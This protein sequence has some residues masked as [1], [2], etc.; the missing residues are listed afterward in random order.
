MK[1]VG[2][3]SRVAGIALVAGAVFFGGPGRAYASTGN[4]RA[5]AK[6]IERLS[7]LLKEKQSSWAYRR[8]GSIAERKS[9]GVLGKR[10]A[11]ALGYFDYQRGYFEQAAKWLDLA[12]GD[13]LLGDYDAYW[14]AQTNL[15]L[16]DNKDALAELQELRKD[17]PD[18]V[19]TEQ[20]LQSLGVAAMAANQPADGVTA[21][22]AYPQT[23]DSPQLLLLRG[24]AHEQAAQLAE[25]AAD[26][27]AVYL[28][29]PLSDQARSAAGKLASLGATLG[30]KMPAI[31]LDQRVGHA[32]AL[33]DAQDWN[34][35]RTEYTAL[36]PVL[37][38]TELERAEARILECGV[39][40]G[41]DPSNL[42]ARK[43]ADP[44]VDAERDFTLAD[45]YRGLANEPQML[46]A[47]EAAASRAP[48]SH[49][50]EESL[51][52]AGNYYWVNLQ[53]DQAAS[54]YQRLASQFPDSPN[55]D[56]ALWRVAW[57]AV[58]KRQPD[59]A[60]QLEDHLKR[61]PGSQYTP[62]TLYWLGR[63][64]EEAKDPARARGFYG[65]LEQR[66]AQTYFA[67]L[68]AER[69]RSLGRGP[70]EKDDLLALIPAIPAAM[71]MDDPA[72][73][74]ADARRARAAAL[75]TIAFD[76]SA[77]LELRA[78]Y[79]STHQPKLLLEAAQESVE[80]GHCG[81]AIMF[82]R[83]LYPQ[84]ESRALADVP[85]TV[86]LAAYALPYDYSIRR[87]SARKR[88][89]PMLVAGLIHQ[90][91]AFDPKAVSSANAMGLMQLLPST[92]R[93]LAR[94]QRLRYSLTRL[95]QPDYNV[96]LGTAYLA[97]LRQQFTN[98]E[99]VLAAY[100][101]GEN[102]VAQWTAGQTYREPAE[103]VESIPFTQ[104]RDYVEI[105][106][107]NAAIYRRL[108]RAKSESRQTSERHR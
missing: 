62:D 36:L 75:K 41:D 99:Q 88:L 45:Y 13:P 30:S 23:Q 103:F 17:F 87:W 95:T 60:Q 40:M 34:D 3:F 84:L 6:Q 90:E 66:F 38:G 108:Y 7:R 44:D 5:A 100:N 85:R 21:L 9:S 4:S 32:A 33:F 71:S 27:Q 69:M 86:W 2:R 47:V 51:F 48:S 68:A 39:E 16:N 55:A 58:L 64:A 52:L 89:D 43:I 72:S 31:P 76:S 56:S 1:I 94:Q 59:A 12:Q 65:K 81:A 25:A 35:A 102:R 26:Y 57:T 107:R 91:S 78:A 105:V 54:Y 80:A 96:R 10:A 8:L 24:Q 19:M 49:W 70:K 18:S 82:A 11:L 67:D 77:V 93:G 46:A 20:A 42:A 14:Q 63:L 104:T 101:A 79:A 83:Q 97:K 22:D 53:R 92:A 29:F 15:A 37:S 106:E 50:T 74:V 61:F 73:A 98:T 28:R